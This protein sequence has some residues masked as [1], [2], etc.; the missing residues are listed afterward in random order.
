MTGGQQ[1]GLGERVCWHNGNKSTRRRPIRQGVPVPAASITVPRTIAA[2]AS[3][4]DTPRT[5]HSWSAPSCRTD[6]SPTQPNA[7][8]FH[9]SVPGI[10]TRPGI[11]ERRWRTDQADAPGCQVGLRRE[12]HADAILRRDAHH[13]VPYRRSAR[14]FRR[15]QE[16]VGVRSMWPPCIASCWIASTSAPRLGAFGMVR[17]P[18]PRCRDRGDCRACARHLAGVTAHLHRRASGQAFPF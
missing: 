12:A 13:G 9:A 3:S 4:Y 15:E 1:P 16:G 14:R 10:A 18:E 6:Q 2:K 7:W 5:P 17:T 11:T 8:M